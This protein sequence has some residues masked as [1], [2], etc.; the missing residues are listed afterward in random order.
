MY[1]CIYIYIYI[2]IHIYVYTS[3]LL[4]IPS[5][6]QYSNLAVQVHLAVRPGVLIGVALYL[7]VRPG[8]LIELQ[9]TFL[10]QFRL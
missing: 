10:L 3:L 6:M 8:V 2:Y 4:S 9:L 5:T 7:A 1:I